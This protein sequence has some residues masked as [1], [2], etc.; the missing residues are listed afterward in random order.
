MNKFNVLHGEE[1]NDP[2]REL[3]I[4]PPSA[5][6]KSRTYTPK[7]STVVS[8]IVRRLNH[9]AIDNGDVEVH[10]SEFKVESKAEFVRDTDNTPI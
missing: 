1:P 9:H 4:Q 6:L 3:N 8:D 10:P 7:T 5:H 2:P